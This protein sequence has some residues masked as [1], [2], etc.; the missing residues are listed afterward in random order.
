M[1]WLGQLQ[2]V[3][4]FDRWWGIETVFRTD[5]QLAPFFDF[6]RSWNTNRPEA[7]PRALM[8]VGV[9][10]RAGLTRY[11]RG[12]IYWGHRLRHVDEPENDDLQD[13]GVQFSIV[14]SF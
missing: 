2:W 12:E 8:S 4:R 9:G 5:L 6:G 7:S 3:R 1:A 14:A 11:L 10:L 13:K